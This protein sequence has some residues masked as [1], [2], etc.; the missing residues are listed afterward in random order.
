MAN[1]NYLDF[2]KIP[3]AND[4]KLFIKDINNNI[5][6]SLSPFKI[7]SSILNNNNIRINFTNG[8][9]VLIDFNNVYESKIALTNLQNAINILINKPPISIDKDVE[10]YINNLGLT[11]SNSSSFSNLIA[12]NPEGQTY[13]VVNNANSFTFLTGASSTSNISTLQSYDNSQGIYL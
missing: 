10:L 7:N 3:S 13:S 6:W 12:Y 4:T 2:F 8:D 11:N 1:F 9:F 5:V